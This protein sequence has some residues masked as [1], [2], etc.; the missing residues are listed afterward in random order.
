MPKTLEKFEW[1]DERHP[2]NFRTYGDS[3]EDYEFGFG[4]RNLSRIQLFDGINYET[5][6]QGLLYDK[7]TMELI[8]CPE[9]YKQTT[10]QVL[11]QLIPKV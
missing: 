9:N 3:H 2:Q 5:T 7:R 11:W 10:L 1:A 4:C 6:N 8:H